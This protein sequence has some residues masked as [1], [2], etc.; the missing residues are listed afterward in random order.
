MTSFKQKSI[1]S[2]LILLFSSNIFFSQTFNL[3][4]IPCE[5]TQIGFS[6]EKQFFD[7]DI[8]PN[9]LTG[10][11]QIDLN[12]PISPSLNIISNIQFLNLKYDADFGYRTYTFSESGFGNVFFGLQTNPEIE[13]NRRSIITFGLYLPTAEKEISLLGAYSN[14]YDILKYI[15][16]SLGIYFNYAFHKSADEGLNYLIELGPNLLIP[17]KDTGADTEIL[18]HF[19]GGLAYQVNRLSI[20]AEFLGIA[21]VSEETDNFG[22]RFVNSINIGAQ[23]KEET[24]V[25]EIYY[26]Y[27]FKDDI[28][29]GIK[30]VLGL[31]VN[32][33]IK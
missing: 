25:P 21:I 20:N 18:I 19:G 30:G 27:C 24:V 2:F 4:T 11:Y 3:Q 10:I 16:N 6:F 13:N 17:T 22:D 28:R 15:S 14:Y 32:I 26:R 12:F 5:K 7:E 9:F 8:D 33:I 31:G 29:E 23:W 1:L